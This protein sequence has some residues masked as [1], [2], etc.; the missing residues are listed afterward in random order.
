LAVN[1]SRLLARL[2]ASIALGACVSA[3]AFATAADPRPRIVVVGADHALARRVSAEAEAAGFGVIVV[4]DEKAGG[5]DAAMLE[6][7]AAVAL[8]RLVSPERAELELRTTE[9]SGRT[10][11]VKRPSDGDA[12]AMRIVED[13]HARL[14]ELKIIDHSARPPASQPAAVPTSS[15]NPTPSIRSRESAP[16]PERDRGAAR[17]RGTKP[18]ELW[19]S[20]GLAATQP[21]GGLGGT[22]H[23]AFGARVEPIPRF[24]IAARALVPLTENNLSGP[25]GSADA[26]VNLFL[27]KL[28][29]ML[30]EPAKNLALEA[31]LGAGVVVLAMNAEAAPPRTA[32]TDRLTAGV[33]FLHAGAAWSLASWFRLSGLVLGGVAAP[34]PVLRFEGREVTSWGRPFAGVG[35]AT[36]F[37]L[38]LAGPQEAR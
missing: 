35:L 16:P 21:A 27:G 38:P 23:A 18:P 37:G 26:N 3:K 30:A 5:S 22:L 14:L 33:Y 8:I 1:R 36:E 28:S 29:Y 6:Q 13:A 24:A 11:L 20:G 25:E 15:A 10:T 19:V 4:F 9:A 7:H 32:T 34:R 12:F 31:G 2:V 17:P